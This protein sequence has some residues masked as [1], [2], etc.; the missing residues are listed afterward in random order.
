MDARKKAEV[1]LEAEIDNLVFN[2]KNIFGEYA[3]KFESLEKAIQLKLILLKIN[4]EKYGLSEL[5]LENDTPTAAHALI[6]MLEQDNEES[7]LAFAR[8]TKKELLNYYGEKIQD[9]INDCC[10][11]AQADDDLLRDH[12]IAPHGVSV[13]GYFGGGR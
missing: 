11:N 4:S 7:E 12:G 2:S 13:S 8:A 9:A 6:V 5:S 1:I 3:L 10:E